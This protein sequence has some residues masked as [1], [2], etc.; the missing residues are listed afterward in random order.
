MWFKLS[1]KQPTEFITCIGK[2]C[3]GAGVENYALFYKA[4]GNYISKNY[5][6]ETVIVN[7][8]MYWME[9]VVPEAE[10]EEDYCP[11]LKNIEE[12]NES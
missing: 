8:P 4:D 5:F 7:P 11:C 3:T 2:Y 12:E 1:D 10:C 9:I 6:E